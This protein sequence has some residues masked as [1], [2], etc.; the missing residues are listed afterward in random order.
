MGDTRKRSSLVIGDT[1]HAMILQCS[2]NADY[3][4]SGRLN[5]GGFILGSET[6]GTFSFGRDK[7]SPE[8]QL[9]SQ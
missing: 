6:L 3:N 5:F 4:T 2:N 9:L 1:E 8:V 7:S